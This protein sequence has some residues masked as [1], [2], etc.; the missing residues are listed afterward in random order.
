MGRRVVAVVVRPP[1]LHG[2][3]V[4]EVVFAVAWSPAVGPMVAVVAATGRLQAVGPLG[5]VAGQVAQ[6]TNVAVGI[7]P[8]L[9]LL[10]QGVVAVRLGAVAVLGVNDTAARLVIHHMPE[11]AVTEATTLVGERP[12]DE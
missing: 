1:R 4:A 8:G 2:A 10:K 3:L 6:A 7:P 12:V 5:A 9:A 11:R